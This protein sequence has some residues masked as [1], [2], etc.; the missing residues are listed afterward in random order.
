[1]NFKAE[2]QSSEETK[3][4][5][6]LKQQHQL[7]TMTKTA[8]PLSADNM[9]ENLLSK[10]EI[11]QKK[12]NQPETSRQKPQVGPWPMW[13]TPGREHPM[14]KD[15]WRIV[16]SQNGLADTNKLSLLLMTSRLTTETLGYI[17]SLSNVTVPGSLTQQELYIALALVALA[18][19]GY[20]F[21]NSNV[22]RQLKEAPQPILDLHNFETLSMI[23]PLTTPPNPPASLTIS[24]SIQQ[25]PAP[26]SVQT[27]ELSPLPPPVRTITENISLL[28]FS[29]EPLSLIDSSP[30]KSL[31]VLSATDLRNDF[32]EVKPVEQKLVFSDFQ[33]GISADDE[34]DDFK[35]AD[36]FSSDMNTLTVLD[37]SEPKVKSSGGSSTSY[38]GADDLFPRCVVK[39]KTPD[40][41]PPPVTAAAFDSIPSPDFPAFELKDLPVLDPRNPRTGAKENSLVPSFEPLDQSPSSSF[42]LGLGGF[43]SLSDLKLGDLKLDDTTH[44]PEPLS[45]D[46]GPISQPPAADPAPVPTLP[47][48]T[49]ESAPP[50]LLPPSTSVPQ[51]DRY[52]ALRMLDSGLFS[53][54]ESPAAAPEEFGDFLTADIPPS[55]VS[56][57]RTLKDSDDDI[58]IKC[59]GAC[60]KLLREAVSIFDN[61]ED[62]KVLNEVACNERGKSYLQEILEVE[63]IGRRI[64]STRETCDLISEFE[65]LSKILQPYIEYVKNNHLEEQDGPKCGICMCEHGPSHVK[66]GINHFHAPCANLY[67][68]MVDPILPIAPVM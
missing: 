2:S 44:S 7:R 48:P 14:Y 50:S 47:T 40:L 9:I 4:R 20:T 25:H 29:H 26:S 64:R 43:D 49:I 11:F 62:T 31:A 28:D 66:Y 41:L 65:N 18:Q 16:G 60:L 35:S 13:L 33:S 38:E 37:V 12:T 34:F 51:E 3:K 36:I 45:L 23:P 68:H 15:I 63:R 8:A 1:M 57:H 42:D 56:S 5:E 17:W 30:T 54:E 67:L 22:V 39:S 46:F 58:Q 53:T 10:K 61:I 6:Y 55:T 19:S 24:S 27:P 32:P 59:L 21:A 52:S